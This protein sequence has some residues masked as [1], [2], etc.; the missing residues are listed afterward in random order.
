M[1]C[2]TDHH[3]KYTVGTSLAVQWLGLHASTAGG[4]GSIPGRGTKI[5]QA[6]GRRQKK[7]N[8]EKGKYNV[9]EKGK[10]NVK[11][12]PSALKTYSFSTLSLHS[13]NCFM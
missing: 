11:E 5:L 13:Y 7:K 1:H 8:K 6:V 4:M 2:N 10:Y 12:K 9:K 3:W